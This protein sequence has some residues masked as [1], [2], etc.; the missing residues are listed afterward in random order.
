MGQIASGI[1]IVSDQRNW[2]L[3]KQQLNIFEQNKLLR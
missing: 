2:P 3:E 1:S